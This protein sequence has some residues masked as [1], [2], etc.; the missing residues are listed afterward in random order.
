LGNKEKNI[1][2]FEEAQA[3][4]FDI[5]SQKPGITGKELTDV[6]DK[7]LEQAKPGALTELLNKISNKPPERIMLKQTGNA[8][9]SPSNYVQKIKL[10]DGSFGYSLDGN[11]WYNKDGKVVK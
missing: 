3:N 7:I 9:A 5:A 4:L 2:R 10:K 8:I 1:Q 6:Y 11:N